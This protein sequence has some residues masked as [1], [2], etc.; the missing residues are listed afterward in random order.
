MYNAKAHTIRNLT[1]NIDEIQARHP[2]VKLFIQAPQSP[3]LNPLDDG[4]FKILADNVEDHDPRNHDSL[5]Q[6]VNYYWQNLR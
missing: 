5:V 6:K 4:I 3:D 2:T 1:R